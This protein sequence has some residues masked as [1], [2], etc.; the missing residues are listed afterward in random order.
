M[1]PPSM[2]SYICA[3]VLL[4]WC[5]W[6]RLPSSSLSSQIASDI[7]SLVVFFRKSI[8]ELRCKL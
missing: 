8:G 5:C 1:T 7:G 2:M 4:R 3:V 6:R